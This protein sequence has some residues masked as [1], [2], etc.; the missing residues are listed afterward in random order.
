[1]TQCS[2]LALAPQI[3][4]EAMLPGSDAPGFNPLAS[5]HPLESN[6]VARGWRRRALVACE[7]HP[8]MQRF[9]RTAAAA[10]VALLLPGTGAT[11][12]EVCCF[13]ASVVV[14]CPH[15]HCF[16]RYAIGINNCGI[17]V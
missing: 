15:C 3:F 9:G 1:M 6:T 7:G 2:S 16:H 14:I 12:D 11:I 4:S 5:L 8:V 13:L 17:N 10:A